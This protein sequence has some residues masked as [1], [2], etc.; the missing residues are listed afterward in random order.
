MPPVKSVA[1]NAMFL[2]PG[3]SGGPETYLRELVR[4]LAGE[5]P[6]LR[7]TLLTTRSGARALA[8]DGF[9][10]LAELHGLP[11]EEYRRFRRQWSEQLLVQVHA[12]RAG[13][14][15]LHSLAS[16]GPV[17]TPGLP[18][19]VTLHDVTFMHIRTFGRVTTWGMTQVVTR[20]ARDAD[21]LLA[22][23]AAAR[24]DI[25]ATLGLD[26]SRFTVVPHGM[27]AVPR[28]EPAD[29]RTV[30]NRLRLPDG[31]ILLCVAALRPHKN[32]ELLIR[33]L[34]GLPADV[35]LVLVGRHEPYADRLRE[36]ASGAGVTD[37]VRL[38]GYV[39]DAELE[40]LWALAAA[41]AFPTRAEGFGL[42]ILEAMARG[43][44]VAC[45][46]IP[47]LR[48]VGGDVPAY[49]D[50]ADARS[51]ATAIGTMLE[52]GGRGPRGIE[53]AARFSWAEAARGT[54]EAYERACQRA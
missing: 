14:D 27:E 29:E 37:R 2:A 48:E 44:P 41:A 53:R 24:D 4:A 6:N 51:A 34:P 17:L 25:C 38:A 26:P 8:D 40:R 3:D 50:P 42:P 10:D 46:D 19:V 32:Q 21:A 31:R 35:T 30:R 49:F 22:I 20:A 36:L 47:V 12:R 5:Y 15:L 52:D 39:S 33:A 43:V 11:A 16:T 45:S 23:S 7:M 18:S 54:M 13:A 28:T 1:L 9:G